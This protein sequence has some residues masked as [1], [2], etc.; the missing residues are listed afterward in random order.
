MLGIREF[1]SLVFESPAFFRKTT[2]A[3]SF[4][5][6]KHLVISIWKAS[7]NCAISIHMNSCFW[8]FVRHASV[9]ITHHSVST[10]AGIISGCEA[11]I[12]PTPAFDPTRKR[13]T[14][15]LLFFLFFLPRD[16]TSWKVQLNNICIIQHWSISIPWRTSSKSLSLW[17]QHTCRMWLQMS[18]PAKCPAHW[19]YNEKSTP[20]W[21]CIFAHLFMNMR[22]FSPVG[23]IL[24]VKY[25][26]LCF[27]CL[28][29]WDEKNMIGFGI[30]NI[31]FHGNLT[32]V[33]FFL[34]A[35]KLLSLTLK[36]ISS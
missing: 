13:N 21:I 30:C 4:Y 28:I 22:S 29:L 27:H 9:G 24:T 26:Y 33:E 12:H 15:S 18:S 34:S 19:S 20:Y 35:A 25:F 11:T 32:T 10:R 1:S 6:W 7:L 3:S 17:I 16:G 31:W 8:S 36:A 14:S 5:R 23:V 2:L